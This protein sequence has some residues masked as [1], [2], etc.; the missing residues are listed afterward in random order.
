MRQVP[1]YLIIG[2]GRMARH[3]CHYFKSLGIS[4]T[5]WHRQEPVHKLAPLVV[6]ASHILLLIRDDAIESFARAHLAQSDAVKIHFS[7]ALTAAG[8]YGAH[9]L[10]TFGETLYAPEKYR[11]VFFV[12]DDNAPDFATLLPG[13]P[14]AHARL[15]RA[16][17]AKYHALC[18]MAGNFSCMLWQK[19]FDTLQNEFDIPAKA[20]HPYLQQQTDNLKADH[21]AALTGPLVRGDTAT[22]ARNIAALRDDPFQAV[23]HAFIE[24]YKEKR[25]QAS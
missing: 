19:L 7:G 22:M 4:Y 21:T 13:L 25:E 11:D 15:S 23:Y 3:M 18:V 14:N 20:A 8:I 12:V 5:Q 2:N 1:A 9:P 10:M 24:A 17:K 6:A 16:D